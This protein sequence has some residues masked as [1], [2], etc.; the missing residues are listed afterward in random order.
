MRKIFFSY[1]LKTR[2]TYNGIRIHMCLCELFIFLSFFDLTKCFSKNSDKE[3]KAIIIDS[4]LS[5]TIYSDICNISRVSYRARIFHKASTTTDYTAYN[6]TLYFL[7]MKQ[8]QFSLFLYFLF[9]TLFLFSYNLHDCITPFTT[10]LH[11]CFQ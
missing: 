10:V 3:K 7:D 8:I 9:F 11:S 1:L 4:I 2:H 5:L 6:V